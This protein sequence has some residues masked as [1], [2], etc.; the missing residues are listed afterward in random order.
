M[1]Y[2]LIHN[3]A[4]GGGGQ[5]A[6]EGGPNAGAIAGIVIFVICALI[7]VVLV[8]ISKKNKKTKTVGDHE[9]EEAAELRDG[10]KP[11]IKADKIRFSTNPPMTNP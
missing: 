3:L 8:L 11:I 2:C 5:V 10:N 6:N 4:G 7:V 9:M 1:M